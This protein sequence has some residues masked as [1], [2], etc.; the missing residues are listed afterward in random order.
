MNNFSSEDQFVDKFEKIIEENLKKLKN[1]A[2][3]NFDTKKMAKRAVSKLINKRSL[4]FTGV[5]Y[6]ISTSLVND[7]IDR[8]DYIRYL[9]KF[10]GNVLRY[11]SSDITR[12]KIKEGLLNHY[13]ETGL[14]LS[15][16]DFCLKKDI[17][18]EKLDPSFY[19]NKKLDIELLCN[20]EKIL[21][22]ASAPISRITQNLYPIKKIIN[23]KVNE[24]KIIKTNQSVIILIMLNNSFW[25]RNPLNEYKITD[26]MFHP[27]KICQFLD[28]KELNEC[29]SAVVL[30][31]GNMLRLYKNSKAKFPLSELFTKAITAYNYLDKIVGLTE[32]Y[33][34]RRGAKKYFLKVLKKHPDIE[35]SIRVKGFT[36]E[37]IIENQLGFTDD[38]PF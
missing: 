14:T 12:K 37:S 9:N 4:K 11:D 28:E 23:R 29:V 34:M 1:L 7:D 8:E 36:P 2:M 3:L 22:E 32:R 17:K 15:F 31:N 33:I 5:D 10:V 13:A 30:K 26:Y 25:G 38:Y 24:H 20:G 6:D 18:F 19:K 27:I 21:V 16:L 35:R